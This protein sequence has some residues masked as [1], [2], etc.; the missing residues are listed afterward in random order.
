MSECSFYLDVLATPDIV[1]YVHTVYLRDALLILPV[2]AFTR[3]RTSAPSASMSALLAPPRLI[4]KLQC[5]SETCAAPVVR[6]RQP[7]SSIKRQSLSPSG[8]LK[9]EPPVRDRRDRKST[10]L[11]SSH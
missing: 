2:C 5:F 6:P 9:V 4:R 11:N 7:A 8:F 1:T 10:R 3:S